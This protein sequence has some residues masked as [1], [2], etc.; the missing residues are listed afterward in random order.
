MHAGSR[1]GWMEAEVCCFP[2]SL[3]WGL[4]QLGFLRP[5]RMQT[6]VFTRRKCMISVLWPWQ[7][8]PGIA[9]QRRLM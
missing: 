7:Y 1:W 6:L 2:H 3:A 9:A 5:P 4:E 8:R